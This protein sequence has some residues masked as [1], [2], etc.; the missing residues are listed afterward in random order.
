MRKDRFLNILLKKELILK[1]SS[2]EIKAVALN[3]EEGTK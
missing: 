1:L 2:T 3:Y